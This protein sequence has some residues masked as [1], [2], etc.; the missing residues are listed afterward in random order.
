MISLRI[1][2]GE[3]KAK[4]AVVVATQAEVIKR[5]HLNLKET[6]LSLNL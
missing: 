3:N 6:K 5:N 2:A 1:V 4:V